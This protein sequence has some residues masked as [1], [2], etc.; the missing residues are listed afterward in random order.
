MRRESI[1]QVELAR[2]LGMSPQYLSDVLTGRRSRLPKSL[3]GILEALSLDIELM[4]RTGSEAV[5][6][7]PAEIRALVD[8]SGPL[9]IQVGRGAP[10]GSR[11]L[12]L[13]GNSLVDAVVAEREESV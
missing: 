1:S 9:E 5:P 13:G 8:A 4:P 6:R 7:L 12:A 10:R 3:A 11:S 2:R